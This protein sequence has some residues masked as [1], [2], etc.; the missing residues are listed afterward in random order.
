MRESRR[1]IVNVCLSCRLVCQT[2]V[3]RCPECG[4]VVDREE[5]KI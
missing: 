4:G 2:R 5:L 3:D 1:Y